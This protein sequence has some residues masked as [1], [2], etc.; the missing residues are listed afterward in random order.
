MTCGIVRNS[1]RTVESLVLV[2]PSGTVLDTGHPDSARLLLERKPELNRD[3]ID[4]R[5]RLRASLAASAQVRQQISIKNTMGYGL[6]SFLDFET[7]LDIQTHLAIG[8]EGT[9]VFV[10]EA[11]F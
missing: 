3:L 11:T 1:Y 10:A 7:P 5:E 4:L 6:Y 9:L 2:P 8:S